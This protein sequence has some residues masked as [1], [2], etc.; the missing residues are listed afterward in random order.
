MSLRRG[1]MGDLRALPVAFLGTYL[2]PLTF[3]CRQMLVPMAPALSLVAVEVSKSA[4]MSLCAR[5]KPYS[6]Y[7]VPDSD[8]YIELSTAMHIQKVRYKDEN[9]EKVKGQNMPSAGFEPEAPDDA[10]LVVSLVMI[11][12][13]STSIRKTRDVVFTPT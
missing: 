3:F 6:R 13:Q 12:R 5:T 9:G 2:M 10:C 4:N 7:A 8:M 1:G 11:T